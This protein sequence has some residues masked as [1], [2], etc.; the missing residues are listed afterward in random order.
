MFAFAI[1]II[2]LVALIGTIRRHRHGYAFGVAGH[3]RPWRD[4]GCCAPTRQRE[5]WH[6]SHWG[7][8]EMVDALLERI[9]A[10]PEQEEVVREQARKFHRK[11]KSLRSEGKR[12]R[13]DLARALR[14]DSFDENIM[15]DLFVRHDDE[16]RELRIQ[17]VELLASVHAVLDERQRELLASL[18]ANGRPFGIGGPYRGAW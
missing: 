15:G 8:R 1:G 18:V 14:S 11:V 6:R 3:H 17:T 7:R 13:E 12:T 10:T 2:C 5:P 4:W 16:L 9:G